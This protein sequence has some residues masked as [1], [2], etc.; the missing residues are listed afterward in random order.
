M[1]PTIGHK[2]LILRLMNHMDASVSLSP[3]IKMRGGIIGRSVVHQPNFQI[4]IRLTDYRLQCL[5]ECLC[6]GIVCRYEDTDHVITTSAT[7]DTHAPS[8]K[9]DGL[10]E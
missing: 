10:T 2:T 7:S 1:I 3:S 9:T 6:L 8:A 5:I 4:G